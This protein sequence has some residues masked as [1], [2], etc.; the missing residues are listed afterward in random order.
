MRRRQF[1]AL[2]GCAAAFPLPARAQSIGVVRRIGV[3]LNSTTTDLALKSRV[4]AFE[5][6]LRTL[7]WKIG[8]NLQI[9]YRWS[10]LDPKRITAEAA[11]LVALMPDLIFAVT[12]ASLRAVLSATRTIPI[13]FVGVSDPVAQGFVA[14]LAH[15][16]GN[17]TGFAL[18]EFSIASK[19]ADLL[20]QLTP[21]LAHVGLMFNPTTAPQ[22]KYF[23]EAIKSAA[24]SLGIDV[25][26]LP[27]RA[28]ADIAPAL[29][30]LA[31]QANSGLVIGSDNFV[32]S[33]DQTVVDLAARYRLPAVYAVPD[34]VRAGGLMSYA[35]D[36]VEPFRGAAFYVNRILKGAK[37]GDLPLQLPSKFTLSI[38][39]KA[40]EALGIELPMG[41]MLSANEVLE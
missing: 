33:Q 38:N 28:A 40:V 14:S 30:G 20:K 37:P 19:W 35:P 10:D 18:F 5:Q 4:Q 31:R 21:A 8:E 29:E 34:F 32:K 36:V 6:V 15:P 26:A 39:L 3:L 16:G 1:L 9:E 27:V 24:P 25:S 13:V 11:E 22:S 23:L 7:G 2:L 12:T 41:L 17:A